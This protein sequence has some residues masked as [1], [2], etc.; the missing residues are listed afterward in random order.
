MNKPASKGP[1]PEALAK[2]AEVARN[3]D[4]KPLRTGIEA[5][6]ETAPIPTNPAQKQE[7][8]TRVLREGVLR[9]NQGAHEA[10]DKLPDRTAP[11][12]H[13]PKGQ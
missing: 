13:R 5:T 2:F 6:P 12:K 11:R 3:D 9:R 8:A 7:A 4:G 10:I 1:E